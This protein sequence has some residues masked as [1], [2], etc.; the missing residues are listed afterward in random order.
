MEMTFPHAAL[1]QGPVA[2]RMSYNAMLAAATNRQT[3]SH[4]VRALRQAER[5]ARATNDD[6]Q[7][8]INYF[9]NNDGRETAVSGAFWG[10][11]AMQPK[12]ES[13]VY[14]AGS[15]NIKDH[16]LDHAVTGEQ[17]HLAGHGTLRTL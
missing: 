10:S 11:S 7:S 15:T 1:R 9:A 3:H 2:G 12:C 5:I 14:Q 16:E 17:L 8:R 13:A 4:T 6:Q